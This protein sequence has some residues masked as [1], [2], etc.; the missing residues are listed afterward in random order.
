MSTRIIYTIFKKKKF[1][2][3]CLEISQNYITIPFY[4][5]LQVIIHHYSFHLSPISF[6]KLTWW[7]YFPPVEDNTKLEYFGK[8]ISLIIFSLL[9]WVVSIYVSNFFLKKCIL[10]I[11]RWTLDHSK[12]WNSFDIYIQTSLWIQVDKRVEERSIV[13]CR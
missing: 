12:T 5:K 6:C 10:L 4:L 8:D 3:T 7:S 11:G 2:S 13:S 1:R 9:I